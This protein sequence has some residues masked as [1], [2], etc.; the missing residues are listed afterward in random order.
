M[1]DWQI[2]LLRALAEVGGVT[3]GRLSELAWGARFIGR[4][5]KRIQSAWARGDLLRLE[6]MGFVRRMDDLKPVCWI[7][8]VAGTAAIEGEAT[9][10]G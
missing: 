10:H 9:R 4:K 3:T 5:G 1:T 7:R 2:K 8:T 6:G